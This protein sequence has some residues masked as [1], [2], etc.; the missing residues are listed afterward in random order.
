MKR[1]VCGCCIAALLAGCVD[2]SSPRS[3]TPSPTPLALPKPPPAPATPASADSAD[4][5]IAH[6]N[7]QPIALGQIIDPLVESHG[8]NILFGIVWV[9]LAQQEATQAGVTVTDADFQAARE[10]KLASM[11]KDADQK[12]QDQLDHAEQINDTATADRIR[13]EMNREHEELLDQL[14][15]RQNLSRVEFDIDIKI[16]TY[17]R[18]IVEPL[19]NKAITEAS[20]HAAF[21]QLYGETV[22]VR[23]IALA[24]QSELAE[25]QR[26]LARGEKFEDVAAEMSHDKLSASLGGELPRFS[27]EAPGYPANFKDVA[28]TLQPGQVS[29]PV[30]ANGMIYLIKMDNRF[31]PRAV[32]YDLVRDAVRRQLFEAALQSGV[33][34]EREALAQRVAVGLKIDDPVLAKQ[35]QQAAQTIDDQE[36]QRQKIRED[37]A[38]QRA[39]A[40]DNTTTAPLAEPPATTPAAG[41]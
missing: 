31:A 4:R 20:L 33:A 12:A 40:P 25:A 13:T 32:K 3:E 10:A 34:R 15:K 29:D 30:E 24:N 1:V 7:G 22:Q 9:Q 14:L 39:T 18:K 36:M 27:R 11:F 6:L 41:Q 38:R 26:R 8:L 2:N 28:F 37:M 17:L 23:V 19:V 35:R 21:N 16:D 5:V